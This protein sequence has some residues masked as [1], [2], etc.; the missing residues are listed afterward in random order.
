MMKISLILEAVNRVTGPVRQITDSVKRMGAQIATTARDVGTRVAFMGDR[1]RDAAHHFVTLAG[2]GGI[3]RAT[4]SLEYF[5]RQL[6]GV[7]SGLSILKY[8]SAAAI[9]GIGEEF[10]RGVFKA[11]G[12]TQTMLITLNRL[13][14]SADRAKKALAWMQ[15]FSIGAGSRF[16]MPDIKR[17][18]QMAKNF[19]MNPQGGSLAAFADLAA[20]E[21]VPLKQ[22]LI[23][24]KDAMEG[25]STRPIA[26]LGIKMKQ[27]K[28]NGPNSYL[29]S[30][31]AGQFVTE[32]SAKTPEAVLAMLTKIINSKYM[33]LATQQAKTVPGGIEQLK[34]VLYNFEALVA[35]SGVFDWALKQINRFLAIIRK[36]SDD[37]SLLR[38]AK[39]ISDFMTGAGDK[40]IAML[41]QTNWTSV[42][43]DLKAVG[44]AIVVI[45]K[46]INMVANLGGGGLSGLLNVWIFVKIVGVVRALIGLWPVLRATG[47]MIWGFGGIV[48]EAIGA[49]AAAIGLSFGATVGIV[50]AVVAAII[51]AI[52][53][54]WTHWHQVTGWIGANWRSTLGIIAQ[55]AA[56]VM[57]MLAPFL[58]AA[59]AVERAWSKLP[60]FFSNLWSGIK[61][62]F[63]DFGGWLEK[64]FPLPMMLARMA[65]NGIKHVFGGAPALAPPRGGTP[66]PGGGR[67]PHAAHVTVELRGEGARNA[68]VTKLH[69]NS[70]D[71]GLHVKRGPVTAGF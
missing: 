70:S 54:L 15:N 48:V 30:N 41:T 55:G 3:G 10:V 18:Y 45:A 40:A 19:G 5:K 22:V 38:L 35:S 36:A 60:G 46:A 65:G 24:V 20:G 13:E 9:I 71:F 26:N 68:R 43:S 67:P 64:N 27:G 2:P 32:H 31:L 51:A 4:K 17:S 37:G 63:S 47:I 50:V 34:N 66:P 28:G 14:G 12:E 56:L 52:Y 33:G 59:G 7:T 16:A 23:A 8:A 57:P 53:F 29:Y 58:M 69:S 21:R 61:S 62:T 11:G 42:A 44:A 49:I 39:K 25:T 1:V 6:S